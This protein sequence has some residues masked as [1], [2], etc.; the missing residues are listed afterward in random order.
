MHWE[1]GRTRRRE[2]GRRRD[3][4]EPV[5]KCSLGQSR[6]RWEDKRK[7]GKGKERK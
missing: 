2:R 4:M 1:R 7:Q 3:K 6:Q 5:Y